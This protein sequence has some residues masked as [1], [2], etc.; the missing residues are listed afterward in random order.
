MK[1]YLPLKPVKRG[2]K[3]W[4]MADS[5]NGYLYDFKVYTGADGV[6]E[7]S[8]GEKVVLTLSDSIKGR[9]HH[10]YYDNYFSSISLLTKLLS[11]GTFAC[12]TIR[13]NRKN[14]PSQISDE[15]KKIP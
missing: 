3:V 8:L 2:F 11:Q 14:F 6:R 5:L 10:L 9:Y 7:T 12:G 4:A 13:A 15:A 1:Q